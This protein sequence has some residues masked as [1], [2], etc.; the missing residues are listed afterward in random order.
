[1]TLASLATN[2]GLAPLV[3]KPLAAISDAR[4]G[5][6]HDALIA[7]ERLLSISGEDA[8]TVDRKFKDHWTGRLPTR[9]LMLTNE[10]PQFTDAS[11]A[12]ASRFIIITFRNSFYG[13]ENVTLTE[14]LL[15]EAS[16]IFNWAL[17]GF[18]RLTERGQ[19]R[20]P[21]A[22]MAAMQHLEDL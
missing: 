13:R 11:G 5:A 15:E 14:E 2:F 21:K 22:S 10:L 18:D 16:S 6:R 20:Q 4:L 9:F 7:V 8:I 1:P 12:L 19:F 3:G 17:E